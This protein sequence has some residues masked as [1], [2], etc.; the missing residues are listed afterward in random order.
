MSPMP[1]GGEY[2]YFN[3]DKRSGTTPKRDVVRC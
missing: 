1:E 2:N 3:Q